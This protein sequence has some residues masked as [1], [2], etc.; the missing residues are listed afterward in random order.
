[1][2]I[3]DF[4]TLNTGPKIRGYT[5]EE[6]VLF[7]PYTNL[8]RNVINYQ[9]V[10]PWFAR[11]FENFENQFKYGY[12]YETFYNNYIFP[13]I[14]FS[15]NLIAN[16]IGQLPL[17]IY[18]NIDINEKKKNLDLQYLLNHKPNDYQSGFNL[19]HKL[20]T[21]MYY[22]GVGYLAYI[23]I[24]NKKNIINLDYNKI[25]ELR[26]VN[27][28]EY[29][30]YI[31]DNYNDYCDYKQRD[32]ES[33]GFDWYNQNP[34]LVLLDKKSIIKLKYDDSCRSPLFWLWKDLGMLPLLKEKAMN[35]INE[36]GSL[37]AVIIG[38]EGT[39]GR[40]QSSS[41]N[42]PVDK[43]LKQSGSG[44][45]TI[46]QTNQQIHKFEVKKN[47]SLMDDLKYI[48]KTITESLGIPD[49]LIGGDSHQGKN[50]LIQILYIN[51]LAPIL[52]KLEQEIENKFLSERF[53]RAGGGVKFNIN[54]LYKLQ[55]DKLTDILQKQGDAGIISINDARIRLG[56][57]K[58][59]DNELA[60][61]VLY[62]LQFNLVNNLNPNSN[63][64]Q[65]AAAAANKEDTTDNKED[66]S[67]KSQ[68]EE[69]TA[70]LEDVEEL[71]GL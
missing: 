57:E 47:K 40:L 53:I 31:L 21:D 60:D 46:G 71:C 61:E 37:K 11:V 9:E 6:N 70:S 45:T 26:D 49:G 29:F 28:E 24:N 5:T 7:N 36:D 67:T 66:G 50:E 18:S 54:H 58:I 52:T 43:L 15:I 19:K 42:N 3:L 62:K 38:T 65:Q 8:D 13:E 12:N 33:F 56:Y 48:K 39:K 20:I 55:E 69:K 16:Y 27:G 30:L 22:H 32:W 35:N 10:S 59:K 14:Y 64:S 34:D 68:K 51:H 25:I 23:Q 41:E 63:P 17:D 4:F 2:K 44:A 1:M